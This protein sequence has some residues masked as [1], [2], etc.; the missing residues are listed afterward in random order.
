MIAANLVGVRA[1]LVYFITGVALWF[2]M[3]LSGVHATVGGVLG[4]M[5]IPATRRLDC[6]GFLDTSRL[7]LTRMEDSFRATGC[8]MLTVPEQFEIVQQLKKVRRRI[9]PPL[10]RL[11]H[12]HHPWV[13]YF[14][15]PVFALA[16][17][18]VT[19]HG[20]LLGVLAHPVALGVILGLVAGKQ[21]GVMGV[22]WLFLKLGWAKPLAGATWRQVY[23]A[24]CL[25]GIGFTMSIF[26]SGLALTDPALLEAAKVG[27]F[28]ASIVSGILGWLILATARPAS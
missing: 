15:M 14:I 6:T 11:E 23:G 12:A 4:A 9:E 7:L 22:A 13:A 10:Q 5:T 21:A 19:L 28:A 3:L 26:I 2:A 16:N 24:A 20:D 17:A 8:G 27:I 1:P 25:C 18:G